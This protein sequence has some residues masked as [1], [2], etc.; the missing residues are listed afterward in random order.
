M[1][2]KSEQKNDN[3]VASLI[4]KKIYFVLNYQIKFFY[5]IF[6]LVSLIDINLRDQEN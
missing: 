3:I 4:L 2:S 6:F 1:A 5:A